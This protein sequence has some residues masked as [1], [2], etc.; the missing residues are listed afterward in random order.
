[1]AQLKAYI[2]ISAP[3]I[4]DAM[5][6]DKHIVKREQIFPFFTWSKRKE[7][8]DDYIIDDIMLLECAFLFQYPNLA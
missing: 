7:E 2:H 5:T 1:V 8:G 6:M 4:Q 3:M